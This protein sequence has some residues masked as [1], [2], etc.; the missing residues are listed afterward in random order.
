MVGFGTLLALIVILNAFSLVNLRKNSNEA[1]QLF[2]GPY[3]R[4]VIST[5]L[6]GTI[7]TADSIL[8]S[9]IYE[10]TADSQL[11]SATKEVSATLDKLKNNADAATIQTVSSSIENYLS[12]LAQVQ[13]TGIISKEYQQALEQAVTS[14][15][16]LAQE[17]NSFV[18]NSRDE[19]LQHVNS[20]IIIQDIIFLITAISGILIAIR[21]SVIFMTPIKVLANGIR[22]MSQGNLSFQLENPSKDEIGALIDLV[23]K[24]AANIQGYIADINYILNEMSQGNLN[25][26]V[27][28]EYI[29][30]FSQIKISLN[31]I[32][33][34]FNETVHTMQNSANQV[35]KGTSVLSESSQS[36]TQSAEEQ[37]N[38]IEQWNLQLNNVAQWTEND[39]KN[40]AA[41]KE[42][43]SLANASIIEGNKQTDAMLESMDEIRS[44]SKEIQKIVKMIDEIASQTNLL[45]LNAAVEA[46]RAGTAGKGFAVVADEVRA[47]ASKSAE[48]ARTSTAL[49]ELS[50]KAVDQGSFIAS[51]T[52]KDIREA[53]TIVSSMDKLLQEINESTKVQGEAFEQM[54]ERMEDITSSVHQTST[55]TAEN[56]ATAEELSQQAF[57]L[58]TMASRFQLKE[59]TYE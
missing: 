21:M 55:A 40:A 49:I 59:V 18:V 11:E 46:A 51:E 36:L 47:L 28:N 17:T 39:S 10:K 22:Q 9:T 5:A 33:A 31:K 30:D 35:Y 23:N 26:A 2:E 13:K 19:L 42:Q 44:T 4:A 24:M 14:S 6:S 32:V 7:Y 58:D 45:A 53:A 20:T 41:V 52:A 15:N 34:S 38:V 3:S 56:A 16:S 57:A 43:S 8:K 25:V 29:G 50:M 27:E 54:M 48:A 1:I 12:T 37:T